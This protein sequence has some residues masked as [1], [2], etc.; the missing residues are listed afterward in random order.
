M[1]LAPRAVVVHRRTEY[2]ELLARHG[3]RSQAEFYL[4]TRGRTI[5]DVLAA[6]ERTARALAAVA[7]AIP[8]RWRR[9][10][11]ERADLDRFLFAPD[12]LVV[13]VG[14]D[15]LVANAAKYLDGQPVIGLNPDPRRNPGVLVPHP[16][17]AC[18][19]LLRL[20]EG[21][22]AGLSERAMVTARTDDG[23]ELTALNEVFVGHPGHQSARYVL[24]GEHQSS[25]GVLVAT[26][27]G[28]TGWARSIAAERGGAALPGPA[29]RGLAWFVREAWPSPAT[30]TTR[31]AGLLGEGQELALT[32]ETDGLV[33]FGDGVEADRITLG[34]GQ[35]VRIGLAGRALRLVV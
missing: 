6:H 28:A 8:V 30:G 33:V 3:T 22:R 23:R 13:V 12:D 35:D 11:V 15:G 16:V 20:A 18:G 27:T 25:S 26:G 2:E 31:T 19:E 1:T 21:G 10:A 5:G 29:E 32:V 4:R 9:G 34:W 14:Q 7:A 24:G 17:T